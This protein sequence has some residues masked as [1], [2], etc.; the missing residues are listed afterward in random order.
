LLAFLLL[1]ITGFRSVDGSNRAESIGAAAAVAAGLG[2]QLIGVSFSRAPPQ[3]SQDLAEVARLHD[4][5]FSALKRSSSAAP[6]VSVD[7]VRDS[8]DA[9]VLRAY[10][11]ERKGV[12]LRA[13]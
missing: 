13:R 3:E 8:F 6:I 9:N 12:L 4:A 5:A 2:F 10:A 11:Y 1:M 7:R